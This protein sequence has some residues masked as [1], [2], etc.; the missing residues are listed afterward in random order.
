M[1]QIQLFIIDIIKTYSIS[2]FWIL[3]LFFGARIVLKKIVR[4]IVKSVEDENQESRSDLEKRA[5]TL[6]NII[7]TTGNV[8][9][10]IVVLLMVLRLFGVDITPILAGVGII[11][12][13]VGFGAQSLVKDFVSGLFILIENQ[14]GIGDKVKIGSFE[15]Q[16]KKITMRSTVLQDDEGKTFHISNGLIKD[17]VNFSQRKK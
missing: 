3:V 15:G 7:I 10:Y 16:V 6:G 11:G 8:V 17:V 2:V 9:I 13:A 1:E 14:Y 4:N 12:L 5:E